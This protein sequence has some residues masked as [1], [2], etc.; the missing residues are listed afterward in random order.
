MSYTLIIAIGLILSLLLF[1]QLRNEAASQNEQVKT[2]FGNICIEV[3]C[4]PV[5]ADAPVVKTG[6][7][8]DIK[9]PIVSTS[10]TCG[11]EN[12]NSHYQVDLP[13]PTGD[14]NLK[15]TAAEFF[16]EPYNSSLR[17]Y[18]RCL[19]QPEIW[20]CSRDEKIVER[21]ISKTTF[22]KE[23]ADNDAAKATP[24]SIFCKKSKAIGPYKGKKRLALQVG[25]SILMGDTL[26]TIAYDGGDNNA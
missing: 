23:M 17:L 8:P 10:I 26:F 22:E 19:E 21:A 16:I 6:T 25:D 14:K 1:A 15:T 11:R 24:P 20:V 7:A 3:R 4:M 9:Y 2:A 12:K 5:N 13:I 18:V